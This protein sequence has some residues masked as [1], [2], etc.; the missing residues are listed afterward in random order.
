MS[1]ASIENEMLSLVRM[2]WDMGESR[3]FKPEDRDRSTSRDS[4]VGPLSRFV[5]Y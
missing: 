4:H 5:E 2:H 3:H 1:S